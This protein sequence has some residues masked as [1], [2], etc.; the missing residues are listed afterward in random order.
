MGRDGR[1]HDIQHLR[2]DCRLSE[3]DAS[4]PLMSLAEVEELSR[5]VKVKACAFCADSAELQRFWRSRSV[6][7]S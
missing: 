6:R 4:V 1:L 2:P 5:L 7:G 3:G